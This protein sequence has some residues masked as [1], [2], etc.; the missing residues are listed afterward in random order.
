MKRVLFALFAAIL[1][2]VQIFAPVSAATTSSST[3][4]ST[5]GDTYVVQRLDWLA[6]IASRC[7]MT[8]AEILALNPQIVNPSLIYTG[9]T[10]RLTSS[11]PEVYVP[12]YTG[13]TTSTSGYARISLSS[14]YASAGSSITVYV[15]GFP[16]NVDIDYRVYRSGQAF[17]TIYD[18]TTSSTGIASQA[19]TIPSDAEKGEYWYVQVVTTEL[20]S[21]TQV[22]S[23]W[24]YIGS[25]NPYT[26]YT[27]Y[28][29]VSL[30][31]TTVTADSE[32]TVTVKGFPAYAEIDYRV[33]KQGSA[34]SEVYDGTLSSSG[35]NSQV[36]TI[37]STAVA[38]EYW[39]VQVV[40]TSLAGI[41]DV[42]SHTIYITH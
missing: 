11:A 37:P 16:V 2:A 38:G 12:T 5:C 42:T 27:G 8:V 10:L 36:I 23:H 28:A 19:I 15:S 25:Y 24:I 3:A 41:T 14:S 33:G 20:A 17:S 18:G 26:S 34:F 35:T 32:I 7:S 4:A 40:T 39:Y 30:S 31:A 29:Q 21:A 1:I 6:K 13:T 22:T 9:Q